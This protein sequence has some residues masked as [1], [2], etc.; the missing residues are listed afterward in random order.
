METCINKQTCPQLTM[1]PCH[2]RLKQ[3]QGFDSLPKAL[4]GL[5]RSFHFYDKHETLYSGNKAYLC[6]RWCFQEQQKAVE[7]LL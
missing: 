5:K 7:Q 4:N 2:R 6:K 3:V 1:L